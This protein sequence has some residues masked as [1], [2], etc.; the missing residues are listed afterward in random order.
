MYTEKGEKFA[1][2]SRKGGTGGRDGGLGEEE[3]EEIFIN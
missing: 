3:G 2:Y 1:V